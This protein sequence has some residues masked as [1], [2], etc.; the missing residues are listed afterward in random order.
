MSNLNRL[1]NYLSKGY[2]ATPTQINKMFNLS[3]HTAAINRLRSKGLCI[4]THKTSLKNGRQTVKYKVGQPTK[5]M[6]R[7]LHMIGAF[8]EIQ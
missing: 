4:F 6:V 3:N 8:S 2:E 1:E 7:Y 5:A